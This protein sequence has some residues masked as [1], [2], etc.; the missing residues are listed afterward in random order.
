[1]GA[2]HA[3]KVFLVDDHP[4]VRQ[5]FS[6]LINQSPGLVVCGEAGEAPAALQAIARI[7]PDIALIDISLQLGNGIELIKDL[8]IRQPD[9]PVLVVSLHDEILYV[10]RALQA[11]ARGF[12]VKTEPTETI[13]K[14]IQV[15]LA[16]GFYL[17]P[18]MQDQLLRSFGRPAGGGLGSPVQRLSDR[19]LEIFSL[20]AE[21]FTTRTAAEKLSLS[22]KTVETHVARIKNKLNLG[23]LNE[24]VH[25][26]VR[27]RGDPRL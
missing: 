25:Y 12:V 26:A 14:A 8:M 13:I 1:M 6:L 27:W 24:L 18:A 7:K 20:I 9:L 2:A 17:N 4:I 19:E 10:E 11:G 21:G 22:I 15:V 5:G 3:K 23:S 16:G